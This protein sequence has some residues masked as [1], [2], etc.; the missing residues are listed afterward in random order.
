MRDVGKRALNTPGLTRLRR[1]SPWEVW[2]GNSANLTRLPLW[3]VI[4]FL[5]DDCYRTVK[6]NHKGLF[7]FQDRDI[8]GTDRKVRFYNA[9]KCPDG[10]EVQLAEGAEYGLYMIPQDT[11]RAIIVDAKTRSVIGTA[12]AWNAIDPLNGSSLSLAVNAEVRCRSGL[13]R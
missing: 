3:A 4:D 6:V 5:G 9:V 8:F 12:P 7:E 13:L 1:L 2:H 10:T 11:S